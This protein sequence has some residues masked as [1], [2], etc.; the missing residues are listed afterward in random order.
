LF[1][2]TLQL[3]VSSC[4]A[5]ACIDGKAAQAADLEGAQPVQCG[6]EV[7]QDYTVSEAL[8]DEGEFPERVDA[9]GKSGFEG[10]R[11]GAYVDDDECDTDEHCAHHDT[12]SRRYAYD[13]CDPQLISDFDV[14]EEDDCCEDPP[15]VSAQGFP[16]P[17]LEEQ[18]VDVV[19]VCK[20]GVYF[21]DPV[22]Y[23]EDDG[24]DE[25]NAGRPR[26][27]GLYFHPCDDVV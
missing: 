10:I 23:R 12:E 18:G 5:I 13:I 6:F 15:G 19:E 26:Q 4:A 14:V 11:D 21:E 22:R 25:G 16:R 1:P 27:K 3:S 7:V 2:C 8:E 9:N 17:R 20:V 24:D